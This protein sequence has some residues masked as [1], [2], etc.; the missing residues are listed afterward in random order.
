MFYH[1]PIIFVSSTI[2]DLPNERKAAELAIKNVDGEMFMSEKTFT[3]SDKNTIDT[4]L[5]Y[6]RN[7]DIFILII[8]GSFGFELK[9]GRSISQLEWE[10]ACQ[11]EKPR[12]VF[13][14]KCA[15]KE[16]KQID[17]ANRVGDVYMGRFW[18]EVSNVFELSEEIEKSLRQVISEERTKRQKRTEPIYPGLVE[19]FFPEKIY[20]AELSIN[21][22]EVI[23]SSW[24]TEEPL[25]MNADMRKVIFAA[26]KQKGLKFSAD[27]TYLGMRLISF[28]NLNDGSLPLYKIINPGTVEE[29]STANFYM[30]NE[31]YK[32]V[33]IGLL[34][35]CFK[36]KLFRFG[37]EWVYEDKLF[38]FTPTDKLLKPRFESWR[39]EKD[40]KRK[41]FEK[42]EH[43][44]EGKIYTHCKHLAFRA[45]FTDLDD[46]WYVSIAPDWSFTWDGYKKDLNEP[47]RVKWLKGQERNQQIFNHFRFLVNY[48]KDLDYNLYKERYLFLHFGNSPQ[49]NGY[50]ILNDEDWLKKEKKVIAKKMTEDID[51]IPL[52]LIE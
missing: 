11:L 49:L 27:W 28:H 19:V 24:E 44:F 37:I 31:D 17:F 20:H 43:E 39:G 42:F 45:H 15:K 10:T 52:G 46:K 22:D 4:C 48:L 25:K 40:A 41:V 7:T 30:I 8:G 29:D 14:L 3:A 47:N 23:K 21:R 51:Q 32:N 6:V 38:R 9:D 5:S 13:N 34:R 1:R 2:R 35:Y 12:I 33:F 50:P 36:Q 18:K 16:P 26:L